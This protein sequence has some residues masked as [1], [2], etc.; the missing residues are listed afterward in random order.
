VSYL[1]DTNV[2]SELR[3]RNCAPAVAQWFASVTGEELFVSSLVIGEIR[4]GIARLERR[5][6][7]QARAFEDW[8]EEL[9][10]QFADRI[11]PIDADIADCWGRL[12]AHGPV[13]VEDGL[14]AATAIVRDLVLVTRNVADIERTNARVLD[15]W[16]V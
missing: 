6:P 2:V 15:P 13:P 9:R 1:L 8:L 3:K 7:E 12:D 10:E 5:D 16:N 4:R 11:V 14:M